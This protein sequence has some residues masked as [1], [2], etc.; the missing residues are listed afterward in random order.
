[1][2]LPETSAIPPC[3]RHDR[4]QAACSRS[5][6]SS[7]S[8][9]SGNLASR[10]SFAEVT[11]R[12]RSSDPE[13]ARALEELTKRLFEELTALYQHRVDFVRSPYQALK[14]CQ[15]R[16]FSETAGK[17]TL[18]WGWPSWATNKF[19]GS[20][21]AAPSHTDRQKVHDLSSSLCAF[22]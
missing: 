1:M 12:R 16:F 3:C 9:A 11:K 15:H 17:L 22:K 20:W 19:S 4:N 2:A 18:G 10:Q 13:E 7:R 8:S 6:N 5:W 14:R 21:L